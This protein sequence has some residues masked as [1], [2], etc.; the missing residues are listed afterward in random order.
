MKL[1]ITDF[2]TVFFNTETEKM[3]GCT[4]S[5]LVRYLKG[6]YTNKERLMSRSITPRKNKFEAELRP[7]DA[8]ACDKIQAFFDFIVESYDDAKPFTFKES[9][10]LEGREFQALVF[11]SI[12][13][14]EMVKELG[15]TRIKSDGIE[16]NHKQYNADGDF[17]GMKEYHNVYE[18]HEVDGTKLGINDKLYIVKCWCTSTNKEHWIWIDEKFKNDPL[19]AIA[20]TFMV[21]ENVLPHITAIK[22]QGDLLLAEMDGEIEPEGAMVSLTKEQYFSLLVAQS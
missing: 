9:F 18:T 20:S 22:R 8:V 12:D 3:D 6:V 16:V 4:N 17:V 1:I 21:H 13:I 15:A 10:E 19:N 7:F 14:G 2:D 5:Q 11:S